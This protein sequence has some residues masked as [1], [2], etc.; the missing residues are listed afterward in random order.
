[1]KNEFVT[2]EIALRMKALGFD[3]P[4]FGFHSPI[5][6]LMI[7]NTKSVNEIAGECLAPTFSQALRWFRRE[8]G[9]EGFVYKT[10]EGTYYFVIK[11]IGNNESNMYEFTK[12]APKNFDT[13]E[14]AE[15]TC[16]EKLIEIIEEKQI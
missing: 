15:Q 11:R 12:T 8:R 10:I 16:L 13:Y 6:D 5:H 3:E 2:Y 9:I 7:C 4:C 1:M 14:E